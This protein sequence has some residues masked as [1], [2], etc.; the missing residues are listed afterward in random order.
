MT[1]EKEQLLGDIYKMSRQSNFVT[2]ALKARHLGMSHYNFA[3]LHSSWRLG[4]QIL[5]NSQLWQNAAT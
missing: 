1:V 3:Q 5:S 4:I 2:P